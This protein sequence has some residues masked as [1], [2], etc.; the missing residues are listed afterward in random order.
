MYDKQ[1]NL[2][3]TY[4]MK[5][6][7]LFSP[8]GY[9]GSILKKRIEDEEGIRLHEMTRESDLQ[10]YNGDY[11]ILLYSAAVSNATTEKY[12]QDNVITALT[13]IN[14]CSQHHIKRIIYLS[15]DSIYGAINTDM[16]HAEVTM[17]E[18]GIYGTTKY[19]AEK[20]IMESGIPYYILRLPGVVGKIWRKN[21][22]YDLMS[23]MKNNE[24][25]KLYNM[26]RKF[27]NILD[28]DDLAEFIVSLCKLK[29]GDNSEIFLLG[30]TESM[31]LKELV[32]YI[33]KLYH[34][35]SQI[36]NIDTDQKRYFT[37][38]VAKAVEY[39]YHSKS[40]LQIIDALYYIQEGDIV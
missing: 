36:R 7:I 22:V 3:E 34:S 39:G 31:I 33:K 14:F 27:N 18:P 40:I 35:T 28:V 24:D 30:N 9:I 4:D 1:G 8:T 19:L 11:D 17:V 15:S 16:I 26:E 20:I 12:V 37:L 25:I 2:A 10:S 6:V 13:V 38:D 29:N 21:F 23:K 5:N 32:I